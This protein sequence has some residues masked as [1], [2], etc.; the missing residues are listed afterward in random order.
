MAPV[1]VR[2]CVAAIRRSAYVMLL[3]PPELAWRHPVVARG[4]G[5]DD[6]DA[7]RGICWPCW[8]APDV[9]SCPVSSRSA[10][11]RRWLPGRM[12]SKST[13]I[14]CGVNGIAHSAPTNPARGHRQET[15]HTLPSIL[16]ARPGPRTSSRMAFPLIGRS[17]RSGSDSLLGSLADVALQLTEI[18]R[19]SVVGSQGRGVSVLRRLMRDTS[20]SSGV[21]NEFGELF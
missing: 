6:G 19:A 10:T 7:E 5:R 12:R 1:Y 14:T 21:R 17:E 16:T 9:L 13:T 2:S 18:C 3:I 8:G 15:P 20:V 11:W 4:T